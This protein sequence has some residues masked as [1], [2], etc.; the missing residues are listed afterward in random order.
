MPT[1]NPE[2]P[3]VSAT[4]LPKGATGRGIKRTTGG[5]GNAADLVPRLPAARLLHDELLA[6]DPGVRIAQVKAVVSGCQSGNIQ[7]YRPRQAGRHG[8][9]TYQLAFPISLPPTCMIWD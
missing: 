9:L 1:Q 2:P 7:R 3:D 4:A 6:R 5:Q 8:L